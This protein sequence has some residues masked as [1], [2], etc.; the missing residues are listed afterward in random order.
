MNKD[1]GTAE[2]TLWASTARVVIVI[3]LRASPSTA[4]ISHQLLVREVR[5]FSI[6]A[7]TAFFLDSL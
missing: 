2:A 4:M 6:N 1:G 3:P 7:K 5:Y